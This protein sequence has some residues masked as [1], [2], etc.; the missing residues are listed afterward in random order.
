MQGD[1][2]R[3]LGCKCYPGWT[4]DDCSVRDTSCGAASID[5]VDPPSGNAVSVATI[6][7]I[8]GEC[9]A[10]ATARTVR[11]LDEA[12]NPSFDC[13]FMSPKVTLACRKKSEPFLT[14][15]HR[16][17][18]L[19]VIAALHLLAPVCN[20]L[21][22]GS[23]YRFPAVQVGDRGLQCPVPERLVKTAYGNSSSCEPQSVVPVVFKLKEA[24][25]LDGYD[26]VASCFGFQLSIR[27]RC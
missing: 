9:L 14:V 19:P 20:C 15:C 4:G 5:H 18:V 16:V 6:V 25:G 11:R 7:S 24:G 8:T 13:S 2:D 12:S 1:C 27:I 22:Q 3:L 10:Q 21:N 17:W 26:T 23:E